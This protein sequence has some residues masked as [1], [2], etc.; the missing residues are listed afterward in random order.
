MGGNP[1]ALSTRLR[2]NAE[3]LREIESAIYL[4]ETHAQNVARLATLESALATAPDAAPAARAEAFK[5]GREVAERFAT[6]RAIGTYQPA[7]RGDV[8]AGWNYTA[9]ALREIA[10]KFKAGEDSARAELREVA[11]RA[12]TT[13]RAEALRLWRAGETVPGEL[14][15]YMPRA[16]AD[17][18]AYL[19]AR[20][21]ERDDSGAIVGGTLETSQSASVPLPHA[22]RVFRFLKTCRDAGKG[23]R[24]NGR[25]LRVGHFTVD[26]V[27]AD[28]GFVAG[29][30]RI[31][32]GE[33]A[34]LAER[35]GIAELAP[36]D[37]TETRENA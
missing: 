10:D 24:A 16:L 8:P 37:T 1:D 29:C 30:H 5:A 35:L 28:G 22:I 4:A 18:S 36:A 31:A 32:W 23:W 17:G 9:D 34:A 25:T 21:V 27:S 7:P 12:K 3:T 15:E 2:S 14:R 20:G 11:E 6:Q 13:G 26:S 19:R 33:V